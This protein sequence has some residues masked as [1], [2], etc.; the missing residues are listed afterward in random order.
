MDQ[1]EL[2]LSARRAVPELKEV[3]DEKDDA[4]RRSAMMAKEIDH[5]VMNSLQMVAS[6]LKLHGRSLA[7]EPASAELDLAASRV[8]AVARVHQHI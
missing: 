3:I 8:A 4:L 2:R 7:D 5:R 1:M 6:L